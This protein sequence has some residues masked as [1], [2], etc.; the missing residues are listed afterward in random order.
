MRLTAL[1]A[2][3]LSLA[4]PA[5]AKDRVALLPFEFMNTSLEP[6]RPD[7]VERLVMLDAVVA[8]RMAE[9]DLEV[10]DP[11]PVAER[12]AALSS[13]RSCNGCDLVFGRD[14]GADFVAVGWVQKVSNLILNLNLQVRDVRSGATV[15]VGSVDIRGNTDESWRRG[16]LYL[17][18]RRILPPGRAG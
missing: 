10:V 18:E 2:A 9:A 15:A 12:V 6:T 13:L 7:E 17:L 1:A 14:L 3:F 16:A 4:L 11:Q 5:M 8:Q